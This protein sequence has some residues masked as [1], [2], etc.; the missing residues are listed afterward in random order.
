VTLANAV[1]K[2]LA[3]AVGLVAFIDRHCLSDMP[4]LDLLKVELLA[5]ILLAG[6]RS[7]I[8]TKS[9]NHTDSRSGLA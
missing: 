6:S 1:P 5:V 7:A 2:T 4:T 3:Y 8:R 9:G